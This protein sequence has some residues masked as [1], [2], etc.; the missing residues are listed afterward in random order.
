ME[1]RRPMPM[2]SKQQTFSFWY[3]II[4]MIL[5]LVLESILFA[6]HAETL[7]YSDFKALLKAGKV[8]NLTLG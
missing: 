8:S 5:L 2:E 1:Q 4:S 6:P 7:S 3:F